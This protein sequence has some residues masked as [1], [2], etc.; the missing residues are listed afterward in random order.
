VR[1]RKMTRSRVNKHHGKREKERKKFLN[2]P[3]KAVKRAKEKS[4]RSVG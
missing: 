4:A 2:V 3:G 1:P